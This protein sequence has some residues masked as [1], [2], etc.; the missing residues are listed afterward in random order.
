M[1]RIGTGLGLSSRARKVIA[2]SNAWRS[3]SSNDSD[4]PNMFSAVTL[5][6]LELLRCK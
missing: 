3:L 5:S 2:L 6:M 1:E 4:T